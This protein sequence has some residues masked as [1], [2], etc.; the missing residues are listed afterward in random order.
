[1]G[2]ANYMSPEQARG[3]QVDARADVWSFGV[4]LYEMVAGCAP[5]ERSTPSEVIAL[6]LER[7]PPP[8]ARY[9]RDIPTE[10]ERIISKALTKDREERY[11][12]AKDLLVDL[13]RLKQKLEVDGEIERTAAPEVQSPS[14]EI[15]PSDG[16]EL[17]STALGAT[18][19]VAVE[20]SRATSSAE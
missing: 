19:R 6:I 20:D 11:Q 7:E 12:T 17:V 4:V 10:L 13:R 15:K 14:A 5:F 2:T 1:M 9:A 3:E 18:A 8:L 16:R